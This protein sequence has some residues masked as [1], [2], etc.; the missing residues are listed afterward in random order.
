MY[1]IAFDLIISDLKN[2]MENFTIMP[3]QK[4]K[5]FYYKTNSI[6]YKEALMLLMGIWLHYFQLLKN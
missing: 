6:R 2:I 3:I 1:A 4:L 5:R